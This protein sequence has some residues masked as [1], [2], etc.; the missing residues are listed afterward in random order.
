MKDSKFNGAFVITGGSAGLRLSKF[1]FLQM[2][3]C[4]NSQAAEMSIFV[5]PGLIRNP[6]LFKRVTVLDAGSCPA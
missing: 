2:K 3:M 6:A 5:I 1:L 4:H